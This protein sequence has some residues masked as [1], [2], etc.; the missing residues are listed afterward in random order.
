MNS[1]DPGKACRIQLWFIVIH[2]DGHAPSGLPDSP[3]RGER[4]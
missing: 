4:Q 1:A 3:A 2:H